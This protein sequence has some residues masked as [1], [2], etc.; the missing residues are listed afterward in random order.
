MKIR[1]RIWLHKFLGDGLLAHICYSMSF[2]GVFNSGTNSMQV[3]RLILMC[4]AAS[5]SGTHDVHRDLARFIG[6]FVMSALCLLQYF[7]PQI[8][9]RLNKFLAT[10]KIGF[11]LVLIIVAA[12]V[13]SRD[14]PGCNRAAEWSAQYGSAAGACNI[15]DA[16]NS[17]DTSTTSITSKNTTLLWAKGLLAVL[18]SFE[19]WENATFVSQSCDKREHPPQQPSTL[20]SHIGSDCYVSLRSPAKYR[21]KVKRSSEQ[22]LS[23][24]CSRWAL[25]IWLSSLRV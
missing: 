7:S 20:S 16:S 6:V 18:F 9:R 8:G 1:A 3:G 13:G 10:V 2:I 25:C 5:E 21:V 12:V 19:G 11:L 15:T 22:G 17:T 24:L 23:V 4:I 14:I